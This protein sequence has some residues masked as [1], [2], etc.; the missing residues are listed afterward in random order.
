MSNIHLPIN[1]QGLWHST[2]SCKNLNSMGMY[3][4]E[5]ILQFWAPCFRESDIS[6]CGKWH[7][8]LSDW[9]IPVLGAEIKKQKIEFFFLGQRG[10]QLVLILQQDPGCY[11]RKSIRNSTIAKSPVSLFSVPGG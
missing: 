5:Q 4:L 7:K 8:R 9:L 10:F 1:V 11:P 3:K 2:A 6:V